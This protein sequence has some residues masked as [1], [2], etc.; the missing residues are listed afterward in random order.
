MMDTNGGPVK[1]MAFDAF[2]SIEEVSAAIDK[3][4]AGL[5]CIILSMPTIDPI[6]TPKPSPPMKRPF[7]EAG[8]KIIFAQG[9]A[10]EFA[11]TVSACVT[12]SSTG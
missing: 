8:W 5:P 4:A 6:D 9:N 2:E 3:A 10:K 12:R 11:R 1:R 7:Y